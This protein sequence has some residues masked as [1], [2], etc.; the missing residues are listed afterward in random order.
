MKNLK[1]SMTGQDIKNYL[2]NC[3]MIEYN[4]LAKYNN[5][6]DLLTKPIDYVIILIETIAESTGHWVCVL[7]YGNTIE[8]FNSYSGKPDF[9]KNNFI[10]KAKN[11]EF[12]QIQNYLT[13]LLVKSNY[14][15]I[16][17]KLQ[18]QKY[19]NG[20][21]TCGRFVTLRLLCLLNHNMDLKQFL[22]FMIDLKAKLK[23]SY[24]IIVC[25]IIK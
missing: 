3:K 19:S 7:K 20:S 4:D 17:N 9:Q 23:K 25:M 1:I 10:S 2:P 21:T 11:I 22:K 15:I 16:Y 24:D 6:N 18:L 12:G 8:F 14:N 13:D 5:I